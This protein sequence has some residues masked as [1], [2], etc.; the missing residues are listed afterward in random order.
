MERL[1]VVN[2]ISKWHLYCAESFLTSICDVSNHR[3]RIVVFVLYH[4]PSSKFRVKEND[5]NY[6]KIIDNNARFCFVEKTKD[7]VTILEE[8]ICNNSFS[9]MVMI[10][11]RQMNLYQVRP[12]IKIPKKSYILID[13]G[14]GNYYS[15]KLW[16]LESKA[17]GNQVGFKLFAKQALKKCYVNIL[18]RK[19]SRW[20]LLE[21]RESEWYV[22]N[23]VAEAM[24]SYFHKFAEKTVDEEDL[25]KDG[26]MYVSDN[27]SIMTNDPNYEFVYY[28]SVYEHICQ[29][30]KKTIWFK[31]HPNEL[32]RQS[33]IEQMNS[34]GFKIFE[35]SNA[36]ED[37][38]NKY[39][40]DTYGLCSTSLLTGSTIF[41]QNV[42]S[43]CDCIDRERL[44]E[45]GNRRVE[46]FRHITANIQDIVRI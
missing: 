13:E 39:S 23:D 40:I 37:L 9:S 25:F 12:T 32:N 31:P 35:N 22:R 28:K 30:E 8:E 46:E 18:C 21:K 44:N 45:Y 43:F 38:C 4:S 27:L 6:I 41:K 34:I 36:Y 17:L 5:S 10:S 24:W 20:G 1:I 33:F 11:P 19:I 14:I 16:N 7:Q 15:K 2:V 26:V 3:D 42:H 29:G